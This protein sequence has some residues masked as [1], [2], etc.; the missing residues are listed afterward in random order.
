M[1][2]FNMIKNRLKIS[3]KNI[4]KIIELFKIKKTDNTYILLFGINNNTQPIL[5]QKAEK[6]R[7]A[8]RQSEELA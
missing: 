8:R 4:K 7:N 2:I 5:C 6:G 3:I 1:E